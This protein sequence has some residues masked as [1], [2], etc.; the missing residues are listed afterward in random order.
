MK[1]F[2]DMMSMEEI[3]LEEGFK[4]GDFVK[5]PSGAIHRVM[6]VQGNT[7]S[8]A[9]YR[10]KNAYGGSAT[11]HASKATKVDKPA[12][13]TEGFAD[14]FLKMAKEKNPNA[15]ISTADQRKKEAEELAKKREGAKPAHAAPTG[16]ARPLGGYDPKSGRSYSEE[17]EAI[18]ELKKST[19]GSYVK[20]ASREVADNAWKAGTA[21][22]PDL[23]QRGKLRAKA[24]FKA[25]SR[26]AGIDKATDRLAKEEVELD[27]GDE[28]GIRMGSS[29]PGFNKTPAG[30][31][32]EV[33]RKQDHLKGQIK[34]TKSQGGI[35]GPKGKLPE[36]TEIDEAKN[37]ASKPYYRIVSNVSPE[38]KKQ[39]AAADEKRRENARQ[40][41]NR[42]SAAENGQ[43][44][45]QARRHMSASQSVKE[46]TQTQGE[47][48]STM[49][50]YLAAI[51]GNADFRSGLVEKTLTP[52]ELKKRE[53]VAKAIERENPGMDKS[54]KMAIATATAKK[55]AEEAELD[56]ETKDFEIYN[57][58][59]SEP[60]HTF[61]AKHM[62][63]A[64][65][66]ADDW[67][68]SKGQ[69]GKGL[70]VRPKQSVKEEAELDEELKGEMH[71][72]A[73]KILKHIKPEHHSTYKPFLKKGVYKGGYADRSAVLSAAEKAGHINEGKKT[74][75]VP[76]TESEK[77]LA[78]AAHPKDK[79]THKDVLVKRG[80]V[81]A[82]EMSS[83]EKMK[84]GMYNEAMISYSEFQDKI[85]A[86]RKAGNKVVDDKYD[87]KKASYTT[88]DK[89]GVGKKITHTPAGH[90][91]EHLGNLKGDD[92]QAEV[93]PTEKRGRGR[94]T[95]TKSGARH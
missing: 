71:P 84:R 24:F 21:E 57:T 11:L 30:K 45:A 64:N 46:Q 59:T 37:T 90:K 52:A 94:P 34:F 9:P 72:D 55:V 86:H 77:D 36:E 80:V 83:K 95:G 33:K 79:I 70:R 42:N 26:M 74:H 22:H 29:G 68:E 48:M 47:T 25:K 5:D 51:G 19:L 35:T 92:D 6:D 13:V 93:K 44:R 76:E 1:S 28:L 8:T 32:R 85:A 89:E 4:K 18:D 91:Q 14:D 58:K 66:K 63:H 43:Q 2:R 3:D 17:V 53:E 20:K 10:G 75:T 54:K 41:M 61:K 27:E 65:I 67:L 39:L 23:L 12:D 69:S 7:L 40:L 56:E 31:A 88:I 82:E 81:K 87:E 62:S 49:E 60:V 38:L 15:R 50:Q 16:N 73:P 78:S